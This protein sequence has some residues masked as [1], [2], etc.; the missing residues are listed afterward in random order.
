M[1]L[2]PI[3]VADLQHHINLPIN[4]KDYIDRQALI[5]QLEQLKIVPPNHFTD[6]F[7]AYQQPKW[8]K[9]IPFKSTQE[10]LD[11]IEELLLLAADHQTPLKLIKPFSLY[12]LYGKLQERS[13]YL[14]VETTSLSE[15]VAYFHQYF[16]HAQSKARHSIYKLLPLLPAKIL[17]FF[18]RHLYNGKIFERENMQASLSAFSSK[19]LEHLIGLGV[20]AE[21][22]EN[23]E[24]LEIGAVLLQDLEEQAPILQVIEAFLENILP[25]FVARIKKQEIKYPDFLRAWFK[26]WV[27]YQYP[28]FYKKEDFKEMAQLSKLP[29]EKV[30]QYLPTFILVNPERYET[31][32]ILHLGS[33]QN[34]RR[35]APYHRMTKKMA[36]LF[37]NL[38]LPNKQECRYVWSYLY[39]LS[40]NELLR[41]ILY[42][43]CFNSGWP[44]EKFEQ[45]AQLKPLVLKLNE[46]FPTIEIDQEEEVRDILSYYTHCQQVGL[47]FSIKG[48]TLTSMLRIV[49]EWH[50][51]NYR[52][53]YT[54]LQSTTWEAATY[55]PWE[56]IQEDS[57]YQIVQLKNT[58]ELVQEG[59]YMR[60]CVGTYAAAC[61]N[62]QTSIW[63]LRR[64]KD[65]G[66]WKSLVTIEISKTRR[67][68]QAR[69]RCNALPKQQYLVMISAWARREGLVCAHW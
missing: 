63:S 33:G 68:V 12:K 38:E 23:K 65:A 26:I 61:I 39:A 64:K 27:Q 57:C 51:A 34:L 19:Q 11:F 60:H 24:Y 8:F 2:I 42:E 29:F 67:I 22:K 41:K 15:E 59:S 32:L 66:D 25:L 62:Y 10:R 40:P 18:A 35:L 46:W 20:L 55:A 36:H 31:S 44:R 17:F 49:N 6:V 50:E 43:Y 30:I 52:S 56:Q 47:A 9:K 37:V 69:A 28:N 1:S 58:L 16:G 14:Y 54:H 21:K 48:R 13:T 53:R 3:E 45:L 5:A 4:S 7:A